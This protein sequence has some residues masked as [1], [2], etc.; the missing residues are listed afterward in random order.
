MYNISSATISKWK[1]RQILEDRNSC[2][3]K[4][5]YALHKLEERLAVL[6]RQTT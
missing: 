5:E 3:Q 6:I 1:N 2:P 4:I